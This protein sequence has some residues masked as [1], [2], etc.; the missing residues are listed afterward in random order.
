[1]TYRYG[2]PSDPVPAVPCFFGSQFQAGV[3]R[4]LNSCPASDAYFAAQQA[5]PS[6]DGGGRRRMQALSAAND[7]VDGGAVADGMVA[8][9]VAAFGSRSGRGRG[10][11]AE[12]LGG[13]SSGG[14][15][16]GGGFGSGVVMVG[17]FGAL[18]KEWVL[19]RERGLKEGGRL[20][21]RGGGRGQQG[22][23]TTERGDS[24]SSASGSGDGA[25]EDGDGDGNRVS[26]RG[27]WEGGNALRCVLT[28]C[29]GD[30]CDDVP[31]GTQ[32]F[33]LD[34]IPCKMCL[35]PGY[36]ASAHSS[37]QYAAKVYFCMLSDAERSRVPAWTG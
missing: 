20:P 34:L 6:E 24:G 10:D 3:L 11:G 36:D 1:M 15:G 9:A 32:C 16:G 8:A 21:W 25:G 33:G 23:R 12:D 26:A 29:C 18:H 31:D 13:S 5:P 35:E 19:P 17:E 14:G 27:V 2:A 28:S 4:T 37:R 22:E 30:D 7:A